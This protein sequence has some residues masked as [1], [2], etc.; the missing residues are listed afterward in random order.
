VVAPASWL[1]AYWMG[2]FHGY[3]SAPETRD[4][5]LIQLLPDEVPRG[6]AR[7]YSGPPRP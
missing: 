5:A 2:R 1:L 7:P 3:I 6:G 4:S